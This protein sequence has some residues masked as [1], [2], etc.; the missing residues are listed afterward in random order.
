MSP[1]DQELRQR[2]RFVGKRERER[3]ESAKERHKVEEEGKPDFYE[4]L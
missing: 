2:I 4:K 3:E 1:P